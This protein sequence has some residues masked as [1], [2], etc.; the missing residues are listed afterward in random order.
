MRINKAAAKTSSRKSVS[1][2]IAKQ[3]AEFQ[4]T[5]PNR[6]FDQEQIQDAIRL[7]AYEIYVQRGYTQGNDL[8]DW[9]TAEQMVSSNATA[10]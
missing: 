9:L 6:Q 4:K 10:R 3:E 1:K 8:D 5:T 7:K 2:A